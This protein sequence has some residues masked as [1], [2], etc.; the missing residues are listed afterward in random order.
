MFNNYTTLFLIDRGGCL[1]MIG[2]TTHAI[3]I[4]NFNTAFENAFMS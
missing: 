3:Y 1:W 2:E 4:L